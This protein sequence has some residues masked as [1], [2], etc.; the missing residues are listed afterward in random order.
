MDRNE[1]KLLL[2]MNALVQ[3]TLR[4]STQWLWVEHPTFQLRGRNSATELSF[5]VYCLSNVSSLV[6]LRIGLQVSLLRLTFNT[7]Y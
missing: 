3:G 7:L 5:L 6:L 2:D 4:Q 1:S